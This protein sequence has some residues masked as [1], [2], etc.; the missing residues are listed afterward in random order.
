MC[1]SVAQWAVSFFT[2]RQ[3]RGVSSR[4]LA[5]PVL[6]Q[7]PGDYLAV[8][9]QIVLAVETFTDPARHTGS[10]GSQ[11]ELTNG[12]WLHRAGWEGRCAAS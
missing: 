1:D 11:C 2:I 10:L 3:R 12:R 6:A 7:L 8:H 9:N 5:S 4:H